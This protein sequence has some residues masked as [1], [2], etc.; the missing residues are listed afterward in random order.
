MGDS[1]DLYSNPSTRSR[2]QRVWHQIAFSAAGVWYTMILLLF[3][4]RDMRVLWRFQRLCVPERPAWS[5]TAWRWEFKEFRMSL[6]QC[7]ELFAPFSPSR[8]S[9]DRRDDQYN[10]GWYK[11]LYRELRTGACLPFD[12][13]PRTPPRALQAAL[14][15]HTFSHL[16]GITLAPAEASVLAYKGGVSVMA[17]E[18][19]EFCGCP[20]IPLRRGSLTRQIPLFL[21]CA[22]ENEQERWER[23]Q[24]LMFFE[25]HSSALRFVRIFLSIGFFW[26]ESISKATSARRSQTIKLYREAQKGGLLKAREFSVSMQ[27]G[28]VLMLAKH[29]DLRARK[30]LVDILCREE[31]QENRKEEEIASFQVAVDSLNINFKKLRA[32]IDSRR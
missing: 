30:G 2:L 1:L 32:K 9:V 4:Y 23:K 21:T 12:L 26:R 24:W 25:H 18:F 31:G 15:G 27:A 16:L 6:R 11:R 3:T 7:R 20:E 5:W 10:D 19:L 28:L 14:L 29:T 17:R 22:R 8:T 13:G